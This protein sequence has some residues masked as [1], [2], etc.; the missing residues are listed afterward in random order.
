MDDPARVERLLDAAV[1][2]L[3]GPGCPPRLASALRHAVLGGGNRL[4]PRLCLAVAEALRP[5]RLAAAEAA[6]VAIELLHCAS[7]VHDDLPCFDDAPTRRG[8]PSVHRAFGEPLAVLVG[9]ALIVAAFDTLTVACVDDC[10]CAAALVA[11]LA[12]AAGTRE[13]ITAGQAWENEADVDLERYHQA[14]TAALFE[15]AATMGAR[16]AGDVPERWRELGRRIGLAYQ[17]ADDLRDAVG[18]AQTLG[19]P[20]GRDA[21]LGRPNAVRELGLSGALACLDERIAEVAHSV[22]DCPGRGE[23]VATLERLLSRFRP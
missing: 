5:T 23:L 14:K 15:A 9:D 12:R 13:G 19:K 1:G 6:A 20:V 11:L 22:P 10:D 18:D 2:G 17:L 3:T 21:A 8:L 4:R 7:L 16:A